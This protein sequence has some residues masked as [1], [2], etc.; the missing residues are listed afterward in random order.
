MPAE[1]GSLDGP[2]VRLMVAGVRPHLPEVVLLPG[3]GVAL[4]GH[5]TG[6]QATVRAASLVGD[7]LAGLVLAGPTFDPAARTVPKLL[8]RAA[9]ILAH[10]RL[11]ALR[12]AVRTWTDPAAPR[13]LGEHYLTSASKDFF[14]AFG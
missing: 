11:D 5:S 10:E 9:P 13:R 4:L 12:E 3:L 1:Q 14:I 2:P 7:R 8:R 6:A